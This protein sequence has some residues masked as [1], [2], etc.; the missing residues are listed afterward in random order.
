MVSTQWPNMLVFLIL[1]FVFILL[2]NLL[3]I[4][5]RRRTLQDRIIITPAIPL[6][7]VVT[8]IFGQFIASWVGLDV[9]R[10]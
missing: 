8:L 7:V 5:L 1:V 6:A 10:F 2:V 4:S 3:L 9:I